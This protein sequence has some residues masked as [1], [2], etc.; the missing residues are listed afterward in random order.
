MRRS[1][2]RDQSGSFSHILSKAQKE[3][4]KSFHIS[5]SQQQIDVSLPRAKSAS[6]DPSPAILNAFLC[7]E[8]CIILIEQTAIWAFEDYIDGIEQFAVSVRCGLS[9]GSVIDVHFG[10]P[11]IRSETVI[12][13]SAFTSAKKLLTRD[14]PKSKFRQVFILIR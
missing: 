5:R 6:F 14:V 10:I 9:L 3:H 8:K 7:C 11:Y 13:G 4:R 1:F 2:G 12:S